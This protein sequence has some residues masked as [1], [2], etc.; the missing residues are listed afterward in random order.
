MLVKVLAFD[1]CLILRV[2]NYLNVL[3]KLA[4]TIHSLTCIILLRTVS[5]RLA[6]V[7]SSVAADIFK[8]IYVLY[9]IESDFESALVC[10]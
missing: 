1:V 9:V 7:S 2:K 4:E 6:D 5:N 10:V 8:T 3:K